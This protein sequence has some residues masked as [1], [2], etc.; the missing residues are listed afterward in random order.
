MLDEDALT[1]RET[2][3]LF[4]PDTARYGDADSNG[5][6]NNAVFSTF[7]ETGRISFLLDPADPLAPPGHGF[8][9]VRLVL[10]F[11]AEMH[12]SGSVE[13]GTAVLSVG[14]SSFR[15][16]QAIFQDGACA[17]TAQSVMVLMDLTTRKSAPIKGRLRTALEANAPRLPG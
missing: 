1:R 3:P 9:I 6:L 16:A 5:H 8:A 15:L 13:I 17:A 10:D 11:R 12:W 7:L 4:A 14:R 2:Y